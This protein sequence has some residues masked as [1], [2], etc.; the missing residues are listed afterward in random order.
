MGMLATVSPKACEYQADG[1]MLPVVGVRI[2][3]KSLNVDNPISIFTTFSE[4][5][6]IS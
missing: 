1:W 2:D 6:N 5:D 4:E 3:E